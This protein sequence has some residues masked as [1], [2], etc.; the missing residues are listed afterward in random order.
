MKE[1]ERSE[2]HTVRTLDPPAGQPGQGKRLVGSLLLPLGAGFVLETSY[3]WSGLSILVAGAALIV[4]GWV[5][6]WQGKR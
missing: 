2:L 3:Q 1:P 4:L 5:E 6:H